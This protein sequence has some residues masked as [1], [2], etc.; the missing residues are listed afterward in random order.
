MCSRSSAPLTSPVSLDLDDHV[1]LCCCQAERFM[2]EPFMCEPFM[3]ERSRLQ[4]GFNRLTG[5]VGK[6]EIFISL[7]LCSF[8]SS[9]RS[10]V[11]PPQPCSW[12][13]AVLTGFAG[14]SQTGTVSLGVDGHHGD[15]VAGVWEKLAQDYFGG[16][17]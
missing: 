15:G 1:Q 6:H 9:V 4:P 3:C 8:S 16:A 11:H 5:G 14:V 13:S 7:P 10:P 17:L 2:R 12:F